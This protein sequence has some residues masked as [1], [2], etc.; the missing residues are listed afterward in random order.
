MS[1]RQIQHCAETAAIEAPHMRRGT[2]FG[3]VVLSGLSCANDEDSAAWAVAARQTLEPL[4]IEAI[5][6][7]SILR[8]HRFQ[9]YQQLMIA[10][11]G[12]KDGAGVKHWGDA[13]LQDIDAGTP[14]TDNERTALDIARVDVA[15]LLDDPSRVLPALQASE[16]GHAHQLQRVVE[17]RADAEPGQALPRSDRRVRSRSDARHRPIGADLVVANESRGAHSART[18]A[19]RTP[20]TGIRSQSSPS[21][22]VEERTRSKCRASVERHR[23]SQQAR[24]LGWG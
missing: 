22:R 8:D 7:Q 6:V 3:R 10:A 1:S 23:K 15:S 11:Q 16:T 9:L 4:A 14:S 17:T 20:S 24:A 13:W 5:G 12:R 2:A 21:D 18:D 19:E